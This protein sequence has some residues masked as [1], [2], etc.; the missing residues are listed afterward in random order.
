MDVSRA[1]RVPTGL[2]GKR[3]PRI[4]T[5]RQMQGELGAAHWLVK[6]QQIKGDR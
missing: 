2:N 5:E 6:A 3:E 1:D 4:Y